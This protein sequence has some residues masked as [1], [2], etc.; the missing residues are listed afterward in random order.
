MT[1]TLD[2]MQIFAMER[3]YDYGYV[4]I[5]IIT[6][7]GDTLDADTP[8]EWKNVARYHNLGFGSPGVPRLDW[9]SPHPDNHPFLILDGWLP[10]TTGWFDL[11]WR[12]E[13]DGY[14]S[15]Q[16]TRDLPPYPITDGA[17]YIDEVM[18]AYRVHSHGIHSSKSRKEN[19]IRLAQTAVHVRQD[20]NL[21]N[22]RIID[23][24]I[25]K[26]YL[27]VMEQLKD[28]GDILGASSY[29]RK[30]LALARFR[31]NI[32]VLR[33]ILIGYFPRLRKVLI[34]LRNHTRRI[35]YVQ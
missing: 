28:E 17:W 23:N 13:S 14:L 8:E 30:C 24:T 7:S 27:E 10:E 32:P 4:D 20:L 5:R 31:K 16:D 19:V 29:A 2:Y 34:N 26:W 18:A 12:F 9:G 33:L 3:D 15:A 22:R 21:E 11:R 1:A 35:F 6:T 25:T